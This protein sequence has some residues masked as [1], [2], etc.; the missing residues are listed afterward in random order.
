[1]L[2]ETVVLISGIISG[3]I[4]FQAAINAPLIFKTLPM[5]HAR[6]L[7]RSIFPILF[8]VV[9]VLGVAM[10]ALALW[11]GTSPVAIGVSVVTVVLA[12]TCAALIPA[13]NRAADNDN[14]SRFH[15]LHQASV[16]LTVA[17]LLANLGWLFFR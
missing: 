7:I 11:Y 14:E 8:K 5:E 9:A 3:L 4:I 13:T 16:V 17:V 6:P 15:R 2:L 1:M 12:S 10:L